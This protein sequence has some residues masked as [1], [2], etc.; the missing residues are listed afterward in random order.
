M[1]APPSA[2]AFRRL[3][4]L[5]EPPERDR[6]R[7]HEG[8]LC[9]VD[10]PVCAEP[11]S[12]TIIFVCAS[13]A[14]Y[15]QCYANMCLCANYTNQ[16][17]VYPTVA[18]LATDGSACSCGAPQSAPP[19]APPSPPRPSCSAADTCRCAANGATSCF[20]VDDITPPSQ[21]TGAQAA[22]SHGGVPAHFRHVDDTER[23]GGVQPPGCDPTRRCRRVPLRGAVPPSVAS[24]P[25]IAAVATA[26]HA[27]ATV[28]PAHA[29]AA[30]AA[31]HAAATVAAAR[32]AAT[33]APA[34][35]AATV[36]AAA[37]A[38]T[39][40]AAAA[41]GVAVPTAAVGTLPPPPSASPSPPP[42]SA[43]PPAATIAASA[44]AAA[45]VAAAAR[46]A[47]AVAAAARA[48]AAVAAAA[49]AAS[50]EPAA[51]AKPSSR[52][53]RHAP[54]AAAAA[55]ESAPPA[56]A[57]AATA[58]AA[59]VAAAAGAAAT[60]PPPP[61]ASPPPPP[62]PL[63]C[64]LRLWRSNTF[65]LPPA[66]PSSP[67]PASPRSRSATRSRTATCAAHNGP[68]NWHV[69]IP[70]TPAPQVR[71][72]GQMGDRLLHRRGVVH[73]HLREPPPPSL[74]PPSSPPPHA[75][76]MPSPPPSPPPVP[77]PPSP[78][79]PP[80]SPPPPPPS[81]LVP[82]PP[83]PFA[84]PRG[85]VASRW[86]QRRPPRPCSRTSPPP[87]P[88]TPTAANASAAPPAANA[89]RAR[90]P[91][92]VGRGGRGAPHRAAARG[93]GG[94]EDTISGTSSLVVFQ[95]AR[96]VCGEVFVVRNTKEDCA[97]AAVCCAHAV[98]APDALEEERRRR[99]D[100][101]A[102]VVVGRALSLSTATG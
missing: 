86:R 80:A 11:N 12:G 101:F 57:V 38:A 34:H 45:A 59:A 28:A 8:E 9:T 61:P 62:S 92:P 53:R 66:T 102:I 94:G 36:A 14:P 30:A 70:T 75:P 79:P 89:S 6:R 37:R 72:L 60:V 67:R 76:P 65:C 98:G 81:P 1:L 39:A 55:D 71:E 20:G 77:P 23:W 54:V 27:A 73:L 41:V 7:L 58:G 17:G 22:G 16:E 15:T 99:L 5:A 40:V 87:S 90:R 63:D 85:G 44:R 84:P 31:A 18:E 10:P 88:P 46:A 50:T 2:P 95:L 48:A 64:A 82:P 24:L 26:A 35:A 68:S 49:H 21:N 74:P 100:A 13:N 33:V 4:A 51:A 52:A 19:S 42:P 83:P 3:T 25:T 93:G 78:P 47:A 32:A 91:R 43:S 69:I 29:A 56:A 97:E 96:S